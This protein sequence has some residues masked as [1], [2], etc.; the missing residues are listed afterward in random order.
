MILW[1]SVV[2]AVRKVQERAASF[3]K[4]LFPLVGVIVD[5][6]DA[7]CAI[8]DPRRK[9]L[10]HPRELSLV[11]TSEGGYTA[12]R[13]L[14]SRRPRVPGQWAPWVSANPSTTVPVAH[15]G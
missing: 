2:T 14:I 5:E 11:R 1:I 12:G 6:V 15:A 8:T 9:P 4:L 3:F 7:F 13:S 10:G